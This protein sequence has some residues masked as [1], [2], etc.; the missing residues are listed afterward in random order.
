MPRPYRAK[1]KPKK[2]YLADFNMILLCIAMCEKSNKKNRP[3]AV[4]LFDF[5][6]ILV[7]FPGW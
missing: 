1:N 4:R 2:L 7:I 3:W 6:Q 5:V